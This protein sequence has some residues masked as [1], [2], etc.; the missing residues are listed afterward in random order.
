MIGKISKHIKIFTRIF[1]EKKELE[2]AKIIDNKTLNKVLESVLKVKFSEFNSKENSFFKE[3]ELYRKS[4]LTNDSMI[5]YDVFGINKMEMVSAIC[6]N[7]AS[8]I[9]FCQLLY[10]LI[11]NLNF[12]SV[13]EIG[14]NLGVSGTYILKALKKHKDPKFISMEGLPGLCKI[15]LKQFSSIIES[16]KV[17]IIEGLYDE[18]FPIL[19][20]QNHLFDFV[21]IDGN[22]SEKPTLNYFDLIKKNF[23]K[24]SVLVFDDINWSKGMINAWNKIKND[25]DVNYSIDLYQ[26]GIVIIAKNDPNRNINFNLHLSY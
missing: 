23:T 13:L 12:K 4:L 26:Q 3:C 25:K 1:N 8:K 17:D 24:N 19:I 22:H 18:T 2:K 16:K 7:A 6:K 21:F 5:S 14:T 10:C 20:K 15:S 11:D 9:K